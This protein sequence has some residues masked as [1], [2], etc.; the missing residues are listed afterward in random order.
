MEENDYQALASLQLSTLR[1]SKNIDEL[2]AV[3][4]LTTVGELLFLTADEL[5]DHALMPEDLAAIL[6]SAERLLAGQL[7]S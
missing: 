4:A 5:L 2:L 7:T 3:C 6:D 1:V